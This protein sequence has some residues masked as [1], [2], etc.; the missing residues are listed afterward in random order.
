[1]NYIIVDFE[2]NQPLTSKDMIN[3]PFKLRGEIIQ[4]GAVKL[5]ENFELTDTFGAVVRPI[6]YTK[7]HEWVEKLTKINTQQ[8]QAADLF[9]SVF[10][11]FWQWC[12]DEFVFLTW[13]T[14][15]MPMLRD[16][17]RLHGFSQEKYLPVSYNLQNIF[18]VQI[19]KENQQ[20]SLTRALNMVGE[21]ALE[22]HDALN[23]AVNTY[24]V[25][26]HM[27]MHKGIA[28]YKAASTKKRIRSADIEAMPFEEKFEKT[29][30]LK[31]NAKVDTRLTKF[32]CPECL[33]TITAKDWVYQKP[34]SRVA[35][36]A[37]SNGHEYFVQLKFSKKKE[38]F[39]VVRK[40]YKITDELRGYY[41][42]KHSKQQKR[43]KR[44]KKQNM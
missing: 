35:I 42:R 39:N 10:L 31:D 33:Q 43:N 26:Q 29:Y 20:C 41:K 19:S 6:H 9:E 17:L 37:C 22:V 27:D 32:G 36:A 44:I 28:E 2:W 40:V 11:R 23:D 7:M 24:R 25:C 14:D 1:M 3:E 21:E 12:G 18:D 4:I 8:L 15:D 13:G 30:A 38:K 16:N 34:D 5:N